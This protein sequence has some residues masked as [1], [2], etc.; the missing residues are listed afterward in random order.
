MRF[1]NSIWA[2]SS[3]I[4][5]SELRTA[6]ESRFHGVCAFEVFELS[7]CLLTEPHSVCPRVLPSPQS[8]LFI[9]LFCVLFFYQTLLLYSDICSISNAVMGHLWCPHCLVHC[10]RAWNCFMHRFTHSV[11]CTGTAKIGP[12]WPAVS[13]L[14]SF[15][16]RKSLSIKTLYLQSFKQEVEWCSIANRL[17]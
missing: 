10:P 7:S 5:A 14:I 17:E 2:H 11:Y 9:Y 4:W 3:E 16:L 1:V 15:F 6:A 13:I 8:Y 12:I